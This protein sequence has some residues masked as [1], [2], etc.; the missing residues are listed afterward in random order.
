M[1]FSFR[2]R[3][4]LMGPWESARGFLVAELDYL[5]AG[6][7][8]I[9]PLVD[10]LSSQT[11]AQA[12]NYPPGT[13]MVA[14]E[15]TGAPSFSPILP[16]P[17]Q[18]SQT[19]TISVSVLTGVVANYNPAGFDQAAQVRL[20]GGAATQLTG[21]QASAAL[22]GGYKLLVN[23]GANAIVFLHRHASSS[24][25]NQFLCPGGP[26]FTLGTTTATWVWYDPIGHGWQ[27]IGK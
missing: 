7:A 5:Y 27:I 23:V 21:M 14:N 26:T 20:T 24:F 1:A 9:G 10:S 15:N 2:F 16:M 8:P 25:V 22:G 17:L 4:K 6:L 18:F 12:G 13:V 19:L 11:F 3:E